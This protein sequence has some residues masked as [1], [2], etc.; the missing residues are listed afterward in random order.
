MFWK[1]LREEGDR[2]TVLTRYAP[3]ATI[4]RHRHLGEE[5]IYVL[6][7][8]VADDTGTCTNGNYARRPPGCI[9]TVTSR[10]GALVLAVMSG[11]T[12]RC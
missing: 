11:G 3:G 2:R 1:I 8:S 10:A 5:Q 12:E 7:G 9:H 6:E 4:P